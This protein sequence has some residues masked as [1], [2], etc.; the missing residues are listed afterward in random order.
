M[1]IDPKL[2]TNA[3]KTARSAASP[4][5][6]LPILS[7]VRISPADRQGFCVVEA[8]DLDVQVQR[9]V[10]IEGEPFGPFCANGATLV[11][12]CAMLQG[13]LE[14]G[15]SSIPDAI[16]ISSEAD[17]FRTT[18]RTIDHEEWPDFRTAADHQKTLIAVSS[19]E[20]RGCLMWATKA[21][22]QDAARYVL[23]GVYLHKADDELRIVGADG[24]RLMMD[25][26]AV[27]WP[28]GDFEGRILPTPAAKA[29]IACLDT[30]E[31]EVRLGFGSDS[32]DV[33]G[34]DVRLRTKYIEGTYPNYGQMLPDEDR[35]DYATFKVAPTALD[36]AL[37]RLGSLGNEFSAVAIKASGET[38]EIRT[39][40][41]RGDRATQT[42]EC[43]GPDEEREYCLNATNLKSMI[44]GTGTVLKL[45]ADGMGPAIVRQTRETRYACAMGMRINVADEIP[46]KEPESGKEA[47]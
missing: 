19:T 10:P 27:R 42:I 37:S 31:Q 20:L 39:C 33:T 16:E 9:W 47:A 25:S 5:T 1:K 11:S 45:P 12:I 17:G 23:N 8:T 34:T 3:L 6:T 21:V 32:L 26:I 44:G 40:N 35:G 2:L 7:C 29:L 36:A 13:A 18:L 15:P 38:L 22:S 14:I 28:G 43:D 4:R 41:A 46:Q 30:D 24:K